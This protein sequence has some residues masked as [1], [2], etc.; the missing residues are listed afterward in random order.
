MLDREHRITSA[1]DYKHVVRR[2]RRS[3]GGSTVIYTTKNPNGGL[4]RFGFIVAKTVG[5]AVT[6]NRVR[7]RLKALAYEAVHG[8]LGQNGSLIGCDLVFRAKPS[9]AVA[10]FADLKADVVHAVAQAAR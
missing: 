9:A 2:G 8:D 6:R 10:S 3:V 5:N 1:A 7:R 4:P